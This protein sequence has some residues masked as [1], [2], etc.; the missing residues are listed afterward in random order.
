[1]SSIRTILHPTDFSGHAGH[2]FQLACSLARDHGAAVI[3]LHV[4]EQPVGVYGGETTPPRPNDRKALEEQLHRVQASDA[5]VR[6]EHRLEQGDPSSE[7][8]RVAQETHC[9]LIVMGTEGKMGLGQSVLPGRWVGSVAGKVLRSA[10][11]PVVTVK[12]PETGIQPS[13]EPQVEA[14]RK[15]P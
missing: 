5:K 13:L 10:P 8:I 7:I 1:M 11:C 9:D 3:V 14:S 2:A 6:V 4:G 12:T 15:A